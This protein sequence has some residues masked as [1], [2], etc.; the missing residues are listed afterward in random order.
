MEAGRATVG[1]EA[2]KSRVKISLFDEKGTKVTM[3]GADNINGSVIVIPL[4]GIE[5]Y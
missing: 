5:P 4:S 2:A 3:Y 1:F